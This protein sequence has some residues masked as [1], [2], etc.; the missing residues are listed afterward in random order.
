MVIHTLNPFARANL[1]LPLSRHDLCIDSGDVDVCKHAGLV[2]S[3]NDV[4]A[5]DLAGPHTAVVR[6]LGARE[7]TLG[8]AVWPA[9]SVQEGIFLLKSEP[10]VLVGM[11]HH[12]LG[13]FMAVVELVGSSV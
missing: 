11:G 10:E 5:V 4:A 6:T 2:V 7:T 3:L 8:P 9:I 12:Q 13:G 1:V